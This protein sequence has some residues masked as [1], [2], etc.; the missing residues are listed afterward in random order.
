M[1]TLCLLKFSA[2]GDLVQL[3]PFLPTLSKHYEITL[4]TSPL[5]YAYFKTSPHITHFIILPSKKIK[6]VLSAIPKL[7]KKFDFFVDLQGNDRSKFLSFF[8]MTER[9]SN[10]HKKFKIVSLSDELK[11]YIKQDS[12]YHVD[13]FS[14]LSMLNIPFEFSKFLPKEQEY[15]VLNCG[16]SPKWS[17]KRLPMGKWKEIAN[18]LYEHYK[19]PFILTGNIEEREYCKNIGYTLELPYTNM[20]GQTTLEELK[21]ILNNAYL[22]VSTDSAAMHIAAIC[23]TPTIG[24]FGPTNWIKSAPFGPWSTTLYDASYYPRGIPPKVNSQ[25]EKNY[26]DTITITPALKVLAPYLK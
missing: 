13:L 19:L 22:V 25:E 15:I 14:I 1:K 24:L 6:D 4:F 18:M 7:F 21:D 11:P 2:L 12:M 26:F 10:Y 17:S 5:G 3:E 9:Y 16:S 8:S 20:A 23:A